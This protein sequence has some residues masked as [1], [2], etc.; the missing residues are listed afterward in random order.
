MT[1]S[2]VIDEIERLAK[3]GKYG[4]PL[5]LI[6]LQKILALIAQHRNEKARED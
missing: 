2:E 5:A 4:I 1:E 3:T 6:A